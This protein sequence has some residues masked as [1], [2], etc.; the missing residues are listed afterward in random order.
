MFAEAVGPCE[1]SLPTEKTTGQVDGDGQ[2]DRGPR[3]QR[4][5]TRKWRVQARPTQS[6]SNSTRSNRSPL[7]LR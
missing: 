1:A 2:P 4:R 3:A 7:E 6:H 5:R